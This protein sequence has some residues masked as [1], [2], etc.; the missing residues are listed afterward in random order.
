MHF[1]VGIALQHRRQTPHRQYFNL[2]FATFITVLKIHLAP[3]TPLPLAKSHIPTGF[4]FGGG[5][6]GGAEN[7]YLCIRGNVKVSSKPNA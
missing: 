6:G 7:V 4:S 3:T 5:G 2:Q 1:S